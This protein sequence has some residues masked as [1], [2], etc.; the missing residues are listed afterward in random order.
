MDHPEP[1]DLTEDEF[2]EGEPGRL[3]IDDVF[4]KTL[5]QVLEEFQAC[6]PDGIRPEGDDAGHASLFEPGYRFLDVPAGVLLMAP[7]GTIAGGYV[8][9]D[10]VIGEE[11]RG[12]GLGMETVIE[13]CLR[14]GQNPVLQ[15]D[16]SAYSHAGLRCHRAAWRHARE[17]AHETRARIERWAG[18]AGSS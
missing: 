1:F 15:L 8:S 7:D 14:D 18:P 4:A 12:K 3:D 11:H 17:N 13:R 16:E 5:S 9:C 10:L 2:V 6:A